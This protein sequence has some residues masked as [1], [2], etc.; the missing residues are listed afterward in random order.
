MKPWMSGIEIATIEKYLKS[1]DVFLEWGS[2][3]STLYFSQFVQEYTSIEYDIKWYNNITEYISINKLQ[4]INYIY[5][6]PDNNVIPPINSYRSKKEDFIT[7]VNIID[8]LPQKI[9]DKVL[10]DGRSRVACA[11]KILNYLHND[12]LI[13]IHDF[14]KRS[15]YFSILEDYVIVDSVQNRQSL[16]VLKKKS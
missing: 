11:K 7:Y 15:K 2:G 3:G 8:S 10:I 12:S 16:A 6:P 13:F 5:C 1:T 14:F 4:N 9:Y